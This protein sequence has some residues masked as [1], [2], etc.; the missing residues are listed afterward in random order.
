MGWGGYT[1]ENRMWLKNSDK[2]S[3][4][5]LV[6]GFLLSIGYEKDGL[7]VLPSGFVLTSFQV[8]L[9]PLAAV[10]LSLRDSYIA[11]GAQ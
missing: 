10:I 8:L 6:S 2:K 11:P 1:V 7:T 9:P 4:N 3:R 5:R